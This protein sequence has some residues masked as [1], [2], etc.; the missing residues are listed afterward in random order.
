[1]NFAVG[2]ATANGNVYNAPLMPLP[3]N[4]F[5]VIGPHGYDDQIDEFI[6]KKN[7]AG[8]IISPNDIFLYKTVGAVDIPL[9]NLCTNI[10][11]IGRAHV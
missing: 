10:T 3:H 2:G 7:L 9:I 8:K 6:M 11:E 5:Q 1:M 4:F